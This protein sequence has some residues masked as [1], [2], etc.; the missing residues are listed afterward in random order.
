MMLALALST[1]DAQGQARTFVLPYFGSAPETGIQYGATVFRVG[2]PSKDSVTRPS[3]SQLF[4]S[5]TAK[6]QARAF[7]ELDRWSSGNAWHVV[8][9]VEWERFPLPY[10]G[11]GDTASSSAEEQY[12]PRGTLASVLVQR[13][14]RGPVYAMAGYRF[15]DLS[16][17]ETTADGQLRNGQIVGSRGGRVGQLQGGALWDTRDD[18]FAAERGTFAQL[19]GSVSARAVGSE[20]AFR[21]LVLD[22]RQ[23]VRVGAGRVLAFQGVFEGTGGAA[24]FDQLSLVG[25]SNY[26]RGYSKGR[27]RDRD[28]ASLQAEFRSHLARRLGGA[29]FAGAGRIAPRFGDL[30]GSDARTLASYGAGVRWRLFANSR[31]AIRVDY[32]RGSAGNSGLYVALNEAF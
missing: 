13:R 15:Q 24:P 14:I 18:V 16:I 32:A 17:T 26:L 12:T 23:Y 21:R 6:S 31:S 2:Q 7:A 4:V 20:F 3:T 11:M 19:T 25:G 28:L 29:L 30:A 10:F 27:Y 1:R 5:Y 22:A 9:H 8:G